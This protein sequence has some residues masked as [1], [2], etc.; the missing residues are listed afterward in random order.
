VI[1]RVAGDLL[2]EVVLRRKKQPYRAPD[3]LSFVGPDAPDWVAEVMSE[4]ALARAGVFDPGPAGQ[5]YRKCLGR[6]EESQLSNADN[7]ALV[8]ILSTQLLHE[9][10]AGSA[11][12]TVRP[13]TIGT[14][15]DRLQGGPA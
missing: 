9:T 14:L 7:M 2:P 11:V 12:R 5:L 8:G 6:R 3:A 1:K 15:V 13:A 10:F 4:E